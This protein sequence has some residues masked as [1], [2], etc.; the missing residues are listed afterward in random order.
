MIKNKYHN[1][2]ENFEINIIRNNLTEYIKKLKQII[3]N[4]KHFSQKYLNKIQ[5]IETTIK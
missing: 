3:K 4:G 1:K 2:Y 5:E